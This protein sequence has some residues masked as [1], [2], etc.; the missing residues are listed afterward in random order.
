MAHSIVEEY[1][2]PGSAQCIAFSSRARKKTT[3]Y[4]MEWGEK[5][6][7]SN[8]FVACLDEAITMLAHG[9]LSRYSALRRSSEWDDEEAAHGPALMGVVADLIA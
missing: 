3:D 2:K 6:H 7:S 4:I 1:I 8:P 5:A 9:H